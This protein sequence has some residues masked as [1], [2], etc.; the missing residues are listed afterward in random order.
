MDSQKNQEGIE[1]R[2]A[3]VV[4]LRGRFGAEFLVSKDSI[5]S[6]MRA[7]FGA[8]VSESRDDDWSDENVV[9][10]PRAFRR[11]FGPGFKW[12]RLH[13]RLLIELI[14]EKDLTDFEVQLLHWSGS[15]KRTAES[16]EVSVHW[17]QALWGSIALFYWASVSLAPLLIAKMSL[18]QPWLAFQ[19][20]AT[21]ACSALV[22]LGIYAFNIHPWRI[23]HRL[24][25]QDQIRATATR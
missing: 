9:I 23:Q 16:V 19:A 3:I 25:L 10:N 18:H 8:A 4:P 11:R 21:V 14:A 17:T 2:P 22:G 1:S 20:S 6:E 7:I 5:R 12:T 24:E 15:L 13:R